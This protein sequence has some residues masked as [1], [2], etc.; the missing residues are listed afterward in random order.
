[1][2]ALLLFAILAHPG[3]VI[4]VEAWVE[5]G[6]RVVGRAEGY[7]V[8]LSELL[9]E[10]VYAP[11]AWRRYQVKHGDGSKEW[12]EYTDPRLAGIVVRWMQRV[13]TAPTA[14]ILCEGIVCKRDGRLMVW[15]GGVFVGLATVVGSFSART[16]A[17][18]VEAR[19]RGSDRLG[20]GLSPVPVTCFGAGCGVD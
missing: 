19:G 15:T 14:L 16:D 12:R 18:P 8:E 10:P 13:G 4:T 20:L 17:T 9:D 6:G 2:T 7:L 3:Q 5:S 1:M 11:G